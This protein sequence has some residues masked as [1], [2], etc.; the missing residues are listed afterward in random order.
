M[1]ID[2]TG[3][4]GLLHGAIDKQCGAKELGS[5]FQKSIQFK[6]QVNTEAKNFVTRV[7]GEVRAAFGR[8]AHH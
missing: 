7:E 4:T 1:C 3:E 2:R 6:K 5:S 8:Q